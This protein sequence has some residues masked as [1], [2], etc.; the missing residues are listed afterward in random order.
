MGTHCRNISLQHWL[1]S[2]VP[3]YLY[4]ISCIG[5]II[6]IYIF[7]PETRGKTSEEIAEKF[8]R[9]YLCYSIFVNKINIFCFGFK[10]KALRYTPRYISFLHQAFFANAKDTNMIKTIANGY[11]PWLAC[12]KC[13]GKNNKLIFFKCGLPFYHNLFPFSKL[14]T[15]TGRT[16]LMNIM[17]IYILATFSLQF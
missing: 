8:E 9:W 14:G 7:V 12:K 5:G 13:Q 3:F 11:V 4:G 6:F 10:N 17:I 2:S 15:H 16:S 1:G